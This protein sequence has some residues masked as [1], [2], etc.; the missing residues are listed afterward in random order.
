MVEIK[1][2]KG[3][4]IA[5]LVPAEIPVKKGRLNANELGVSKVIGRRPKVKTDP[6]KKRV[7]RVIEDNDDILEI[8]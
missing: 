5:T 1:D 7:R 4:L 3:K 2:D 8:D 6:E